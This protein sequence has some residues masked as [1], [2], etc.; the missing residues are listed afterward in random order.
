MLLR[1]AVAYRDIKVPLML[2]GFAVGAGSIVIGL[3]MTWYRLAPAFLPSSTFQQTVA[4]QSITELN[5]QRTQKES[6]ELQ[7]QVDAFAQEYPGQVSVVVTD[8]NDQ[9]TAA[10]DADNVTVSASLYKMFV[11][12]GVY[13]RIDAGSLTI[14]SQTSTGLT[15]G[16]CLYAMITV[17]DNDCGF[18]LG[19]M[20]GWA[21]LDASLAGL[22]LTN[23]RTNNYDSAYNLLGDKTTTARDVALFMA[24]LYQGSLLS[25]KSTDAF[26]T[27]L[28]E[29]KLNTGLPSGLPDSAVIAHKTGSLYDVV[30]DAG[31]IYSGNARYLLVVMT[32]GWQD[33]IRQPPAA[34]ADISSKMWQYFTS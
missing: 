29:D 8:L 23:T 33:P 1:W 14:Q 19:S 10:T 26:L 11:A 15:V 7:A 24:K 6:A 30:H 16:G 17:S 28:K 18:A 5:R 22:G 25:A 4:T 32:R 34:F 3:V 13:R 9:A 2:T 27:L 31:I 21:Y 12:W 20:V